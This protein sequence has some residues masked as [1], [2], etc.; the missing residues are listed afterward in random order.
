MN[1]KPIQISAFSIIL[2]VIFIILSFTF[3]YPIYFQI[4]ASFSNPVKV[5]ATPFL[6][7]PVDPGIGVYKL[8]LNYEIVWIGYRNSLVYLMLTLIFSV[9][10]TMMGAYAL[11][12]RNLAGRKYVLFFIII[13]MFINGG[14][15]PTFLVVKS[16]G[17]YNSIW[18]MV[19][20][21]LIGVWNLL[22]SKTFIASNIPDELY[23][24]AVID[25]A[26]EVRFFLTILLPLSKALIAVLIL[27]YGSSR[28]NAFFDALIYLRERTRHPLQLILREILI[29]D[30]IAMEMGG[31][32]GSSEF[33]WKEGIKYGVTVVSIAPLLILF[34]FVQ[35]YFVKG[36]MIGSI[37]E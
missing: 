29:Q 34:P 15:I 16:L 18:A 23:E 25:G 9:S 2:N 6:Y 13:T 37:K 31:D 10:T 35:R 8:L 17:L 3:L 21:S 1:R 22:I 19:F 33:F 14:M 11:S 20:P 28:W 32:V 5:A 26:G 27:Y 30:R 4:I 24:A 7:L 36:I 12:R